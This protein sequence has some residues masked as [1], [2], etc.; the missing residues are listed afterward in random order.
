[1]KF[2]IV[3]CMLLS[4]AFGWPKKTELTN[5]EAFWNEVREGRIVGGQAAALGQFPF[6]AALLLRGS[7]N[8][9]SWIINARTIGTAAH[10]IS[11]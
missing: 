9:G 10:C 11:G 6:Q 8:C 2:S 7:L 4:V 5:A 1:M 3:L